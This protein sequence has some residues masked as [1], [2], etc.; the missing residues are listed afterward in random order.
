MTHTPEQW[1]IMKPQRTSLHLIELLSTFKHHGGF[2]Y[3][4]PILLDGDT[5]EEAL[6]SKLVLFEDDMPLRR[7]HEHHG[8]IAGTGRGA[9]SHWQRYLF[10]SSSDNTD[11]N[12]NGRSYSYAVDRSRQH[13]PREDGRTLLNG[14][15][16]IQYGRCWGVVVAEDGDDAET[17]TLSKLQLYE[18]SKLL[19]PSHAVHT[20]IEQIG[21]G[22]YSHWKR[23]LYFSSSDGSDPN[24]NGRVYSFELSVGDMISNGIQDLSCHN[25]RVK[26]NAPFRHREGLSWGIAVPEDGDILATEALSKMRL[27]ENGAAIGPGHAL[28]TDIEQNG[29][30]RYSHWKKYLFFSTSDGSD[31][32]TNGRLY[33]YDFEA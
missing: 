22:R 6:R 19:G 18:D 32:N 10:F 25:G 24:L 30:G 9:Y 5:A 33:T 1:I 3:G 4:M 7:G 20:E 27:Y 21:A 29:A 11:P 23:Y 14:P 15:F 13:K 16:Y 8:T 17:E 26:L 28:H 12:K 2:S 31:P